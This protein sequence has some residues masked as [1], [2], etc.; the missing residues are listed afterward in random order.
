MVAQVRRAPPQVR[1]PDFNQSLIHLTKERREEAP[2]TSPD[3]TPRVVEAFDV[4]K[5]ILASGVVRGSGRTGYIK[6]Q[7][8]AACFTEVPLSAVHHIASEPGAELRKY[9]YY[10]IAVSKRAVFAAGGRPVIYV[11]DDEGG[12]IPDNEKWRQVRFEA[13]ADDWRVNWTHERE[14][15]VPDQLELS[16]IPE[17]HILVWSAAEAEEIRVFDSPVRGRIVSILPMQQLVQML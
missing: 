8:P 14:W 7:R 16:T 10:G 13:E 2:K 11:P 15:R 1:R 5:E 3:Q 9:R 12:W 17:L 6:G 4:L